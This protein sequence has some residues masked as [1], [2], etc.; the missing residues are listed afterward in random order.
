MNPQI[1]TKSIELKELGAEGPGSFIGYPSKFYGLDDYGDV[2]LPGAYTASIPSFLERGF[3]AHSHDWGYDGVIGYPTS[4]I[5]DSVG[6]KCETVFHSTE[7]AQRVRT[8]ASERMAAGKKVFLSIGFITK[9]ALW[10]DCED[11][12]AILPAFIPAE[13]LAVI[14]SEIDEYC[15]VR[16]LM[17]IELYE[18]SIVT[19]PAQRSAE[20]LEVRSAKPETKT[21]PAT[22]PHAG[23]RFADEL[24]TAHA[25]VKAV[26]SVAERA[27]DIAAK[28]REEKAGRAI[29]AARRETLQACYDALTESC[30]V[31]KA[32]LDETAPVEDEPKAS[33]EDV[34]KAMAAY[35]RTQ[36]RLASAAQV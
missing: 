4:A 10:V 30:T 16:L 31:L 7:D 17:E 15:G 21:D 2:I 23:V 11:Y 6:L 25:A 22:T 8:K 36:A 5:E 9:K 20:V 32:V 28:R 27:R 12:D 29:S 14:R 24:A 35:A 13:K 1:E 3:T 26:G 19:A 33:V 18:Y 34:Q